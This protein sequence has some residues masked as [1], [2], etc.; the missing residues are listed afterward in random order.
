MSDWNLEASGEGVQIGVEHGA[1]GVDSCNRVWPVQDKKRKIFPGRLFHAIEHGA[2]VGVKA[3]ADI[4]YIEDQG[5]NV[6]E[7][8]GLNPARRSLIEAENGQTRSRIF[9]IRNIRA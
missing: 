1:L 5:I 8:G 7:H 3:R 2:R 9:C 4:L 6:R